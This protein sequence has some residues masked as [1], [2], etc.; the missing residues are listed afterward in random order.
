MLFDYLEGWKQLVEIGS[1]YSFW[2]DVKGGV[3]QGSILVPLFF[4]VFIND[5]FMFIESYEICNFADDSTLYSSGIEL[6]SILEN[7]KHDMK[8]ILKWFRTNSL[9]VN[10]GKFK[11]MNLD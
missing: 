8:A 10:P 1:S 2:S 3:P 9:K 5:L 6:S 7:L 11:F 4:N